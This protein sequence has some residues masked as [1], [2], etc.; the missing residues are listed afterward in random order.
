[1]ADLIFMKSEALVVAR[2]F[3]EIYP[4]F[5]FVLGIRFDILTC[6]WY[7]HML[8]FGLNVTQKRRRRQAIDVQQRGLAGVPKTISGFLTKL[9][10]LSD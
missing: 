9:M 2:L 4:S 10:I 8:L 5:F 1:M 6:R 7:L 3:T